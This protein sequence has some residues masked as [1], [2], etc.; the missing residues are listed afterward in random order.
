MHVY[1]SS[2][3][4]PPTV[5]FHLQK[6]TILPPRPS[7]I[8]ATNIDLACPTNPDHH[9]GLPL[10][11]NSSGNHKTP[12]RSLPNNLAVTTLRV[13]PITANTYRHLLLYKAH[14]TMGKI[15]LNSSHSPPPSVDCHL[16]KITILPPSPSGITATDISL[17]CP[18]NPD[19]RPGLPLPPNS[20]R[21]H[22]TPHR[23]LPNNLAVTT[24]RVT[25]ITANTYRHLLHYKAYPTMVSYHQIV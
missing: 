9:P 6:I 10:P 14:P 2:H 25:P 24:L 15:E 5:D 19:H 11:P 16:Q 17:D 20:S 12:H 1:N 18:T 23:S 3:S 22:K 21:N 8:T 7:G 4:P 13:T